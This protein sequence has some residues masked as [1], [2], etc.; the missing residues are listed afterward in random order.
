VLQAPNFFQF[1]AGNDSASGGAKGDHFLGGPGNDS[2]DGGAGIDVA[3]WLTADSGFSI[4][5]LNDL[6]YQVTDNGVGSPNGTDTVSN[7]EVIAFSN[8]DEY[9]PQFVSGGG[10]ASAS[11]VVYENQSAVT[12][13]MAQDANTADSSGQ[14]LAYFLVGGPDQGRFLIDA[15]TGKVGFKLAPDHEAP[16]DANKDNHYQV[17][18]QVSDGMTIDRQTL[19]IKVLDVSG[20]TITGTAAADRI[21]ASHAPVGQHKSTPEADTI[22]GLSGNDIIFSLGGDDTVIGGLGIDFLAGGAGRDFFVFNAPLSPA[23]RDVVHDFSHVDDT[24]RL[25]NAVM[26]AFVRPGALNPAFFYLGSAAHDGN[27][28]IIYNKATGGLFYDSNGSLA[29][30]VTQLATLT[31]KPTLQANDF[32]VI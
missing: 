14:Q 15:S 27:D 17:V 21:D 25:E 13:V 3:H 20:F 23:N 28:H 32:V 18:V 31:S 30:G 16:A 6:V 4:H 19:D 2:F 22:R 12:T 10:G 9:I 7:V 5:W 11:Y 24:F 26:K 29:G 1:G 8:L